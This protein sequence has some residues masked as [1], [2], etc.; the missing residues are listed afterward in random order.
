MNKGVAN[1]WRYYQ[2]GCGANKR[3]LQALTAAP[4]HGHGVAALDALGRPCVRDGRRWSRFQP[5]A[6]DDVALF[7]ACMAG[8]NAITGFRNADLTARLYPQP[9]ADRAEARRRCARTSRLIAKLRGHGL[10][11]KVKDARLYRP[12]PHGQK[13]MS[14]AIHTRLR[15]FP[16][17]YAIAPP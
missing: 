8:E 6:A 5:L 16:R 2:V 10:V 11:A 14:A 15:D 17:A 12:T 9:S 3:Y 1:T 4:V 7:A 13:V